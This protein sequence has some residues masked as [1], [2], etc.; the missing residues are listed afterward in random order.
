MTVEER[1]FLEISKKYELPFK[2]AKNK[3]LLDGFIPSFVAFNF[4]PKIM[5]RIGNN[6]DY[7][8]IAKSLE[9]KGFAVWLYEKCPAEE[10]V[11]T[12]WNTIAEQ[13]LRNDRRKN[14]Q[15]ASVFAREFNSVSYVEPDWSP[16]YLGRVLRKQSQFPYQICGAERE[17]G[18]VCTARPALGSFR[19]YKHGGKFVNNLRENVTGMIEQIDKG[20]LDEENL[21][22]VF[23][24]LLPNQQADT[25][26]KLKKQIK[27]EPEKFADETLDNLIILL[28]MKLPHDLSSTNYKDLYN[29]IKEIRALFLDRKISTVGREGTAQKLEVNANVQ[30]DLAQLLSKLADRKRKEEELQSGEVKAV[31]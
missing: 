17:N 29:T 10:E 8:D 7:F 3:Y 11:S 16:E 23:V 6:G 12:R 19:C 13:I 24:K 14:E 2:Y 22:E 26:W 21:T 27:R 15:F 20:T 5:V 25:F 1:K 30:T 31:E 28:V 18:E 9:R 4:E